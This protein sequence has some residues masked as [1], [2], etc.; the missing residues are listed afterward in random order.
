MVI[1][2][3]GMR[4]ADQYNRIVSESIVRKSF[5]ESVPGGPRSQAIRNHD[6][7]DIDQFEQA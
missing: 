6:I 3:C 2:V 4:S 7:D 5:V 1:H